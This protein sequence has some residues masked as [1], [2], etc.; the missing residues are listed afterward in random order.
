MSLP[1]GDPERGKQVFMKACSHC[2]SIEP[3]G[4]TVYG[5]N[6][7][8]MFGRK[9][10]TIEGYKY[11]DSHKAIDAKWD[12][13]HLNEYLEGNLGLINP[14]IYIVEMYSWQILI[15]WHPG[16]KNIIMA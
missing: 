10:G 6:L 11:T 5:P 16:Q 14:F 7:F 13:A 2:H 3:N 15:K 12:E 4:K 9:S 1:P 8:G